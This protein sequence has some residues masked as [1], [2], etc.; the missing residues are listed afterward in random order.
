MVD[1]GRNEEDW[2]FRYNNIV[3]LDGILVP[4]AKIVGI[5]EVGIE[6]GSAKQLNKEEIDELFD[7]TETFVDE[8]GSEHV[9]FSFEV[10]ISQDVEIFAGEETKSIPICRGT[11]DEAETERKEL[12]DKIE[13]YYERLINGDRK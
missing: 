3:Y 13:A 12:A 10:F 7:R 4:I 11:H 2:R 5:T 6:S 8:D 9:P 1:M